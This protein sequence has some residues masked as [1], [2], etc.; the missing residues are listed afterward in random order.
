MRKNII[1]LIIVIHVL[2]F[3][4]FSNY[5]YGQ[6]DKIYS[7]REVLEIL[8]NSPGFL[9]DKKIKV[10][11][12]VVGMKDHGHLAGGF[13]HWFTYELADEDILKLELRNWDSFPKLDA[14]ILGKPEEIIRLYEGSI[15]IKK[16]I[17]EYGIFE[18]HF[19]HK[20]YPY[21]KIKDFWKYFWVES[22]EYL[23]LPFSYPKREVTV[24]S[25]GFI[26]DGRYIK[27]PY[28]F[29]LKDNK[30]FIN[31]IEIVS[32]SPLWLAMSAWLPTIQPEY[33]CIGGSMIS[34]FESEVEFFKENGILIM[35]KTGSRIGIPC[36]TKEDINQLLRKID[37]II[38]SN[39]TLK[40]K[41]KELSSIEEIKDFYFIIEDI[42]KNWKRVF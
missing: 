27:P 25:G 11:A 23:E 41:R 39:K 19:F 29:I 6:E 15:D 7:V 26:Y 33:N 5:I 13:Y 28:H 40:E 20:Q 9:K 10:K 24:D 3:L 21:E 35:N 38:F 18:G 36:R 8:I 2:N 4:I 42:L 16:E 30:I 14:V 34:L 17:P 31:N 32:G 12:L 1:F 37:E 22:Y